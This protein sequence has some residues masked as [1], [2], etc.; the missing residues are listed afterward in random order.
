MSK[1]KLLGLSCI[2][3]LAAL[4]QP[5]HAQYMYL[6]TDGD[7]VSTEGD[8]LSTGGTTL[9]AL[10]LNTNHDR[11]GTVRACN[12]HTGAPTS[13]ALLGLISYTI[14]LRAEGGTVDWGTFASQDPAFAVLGTDLAGNYETEFT[15]MRPAGTTT[16]PGLVRLGTIS[17][18]ITSGAPRINISSYMSLDPYAFGTGF[19]TPCEGSEVA[20]TYVLGTDWFDADAAGREGTA[21]R[22]SDPP[23]MNTTGTGKIYLGGNLIPGPYVLSF[24]AGKLAVNGLMLPTL[25]RQATPHSRSQ[26]E[27]EQLAF[28]QRAADVADSLSSR[29]S[30]PEEIGRVLYSMCTSSSF[31]DSAKVTSRDVSWKFRD[32]TLMGISTEPRPASVKPVP[33]E[34][35]EQ[36]ELREIRRSID[37]GSTVFILATGTRI[38]V[39]PGKAAQVDEMVS[40]VKVQNLQGKFPPRLEEELRTPVQL[41]R[42]K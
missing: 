42:I 20:N 34:Q 16:P 3:V 6:D 7:G 32:G 9:V 26:Q 4:P 18:T 10:Y 23:P 37:S 29:G 36:H 27:R 35:I 41:E 39:P 25:E 28:G 21:L 30:T 13:G 8:T 24:N 17:V 11:D 2:F 12:A 1:L 5:A 40:L 15:R 22:G 31:V 38:T 19:G 33:R 14:I